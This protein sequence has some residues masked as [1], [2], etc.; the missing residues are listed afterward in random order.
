MKPLCP[1]GSDKTYELCC[2]P[3]IAGK[4]KPLWP[5]ELMRSRYTAY[6]LGKLNYI[7]KTMKA[8][9]AEGFDEKQARS[10]A[11]VIKWLKLEVLASQT[12][13]F[14]GTVEFKAYYLYKNQ[15]H[16]MHE[17]SEFRLENEQWYY[18]DG[19]MKW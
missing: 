2:D 3:F 15:K 16:M 8:P 5:E 18:V 19:K 10:E 13:G 11:L 7:M 4:K 17:V 12:Q 9:A 14:T 1:C 6:A